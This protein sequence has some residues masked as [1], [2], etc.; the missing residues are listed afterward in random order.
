MHFTLLEEGR[1]KGW[2]KLDNL[3]VDH[4]LLDNLH[5][6]T[7]ELLLAKDP[8]NDTNI[9]SALFWWSIQ[10]PNVCPSPV[11]F[12]PEER[13]QRLIR[14]RGATGTPTLINIARN[15]VLSGI[16]F[17]KED[18][19]LNNDQGVFLVH[20][21]AYSGNLSLFALPD[22]EP[23]LFKTTKNGSSACH[24][25]AQGGHIAKLPENLL[26]SEQ[27]R[28]CTANG[29]RPVH[30]AA[31]HGK[32]KEF[33][34]Q[35]P[36]HLAGKEEICS[37]DKSGYNYAHLVAERHLEPMHPGWPYLN[38]MLLV[39]DNMG[40]NPLHL[41]FAEPNETN[42]KL[43]PKSVFTRR[44]LRM[45][46]KK[47]RVPFKNNG[48]ERSDLASLLHNYDFTPDEKRRFRVTDLLGQSYKYIG[49]PPIQVE[50]PNL[51]TD[52]IQ[53]VIHQLDP[54]N[55]ASTC[56]QEKAYR[57]SLELLLNEP[58]QRITKILGPAWLRK[59]LEDILRGT[60]GQQAMKVISNLIPP[61]NTDN[62]IF[63]L[64]Q[65]GHLDLTLLGIQSSENFIDLRKQVLTRLQQ[66]VHSAPKSFNGCVLAYCRTWVQWE[67]L[68]PD[69]ARKLHPLIM[70]NSPQ[71]FK[72]KSFLPIFEAAL[73]ELKDS[74][75]AL[76]AAVGVAYRL[77]VVYG[78]IQEVKKAV[79]MPA[80]CKNPLD[81]INYP[82]FELA[83]FSL[84]TNGIWSIKEWRK[85]LMQRPTKAQIRTIVRAPEIEKLLG[86]APTGW[87]EINQTIIKL[88]ERKHGLPDG[89]IRLGQQFFLTEAQILD[90]QRLLKKAKT[91]ENCPP[92][93]F[94]HAGNIFRQLAPLDPLG[95]ML[96]YTTKC[97]QILH[98][99]GAMYASTGVTDP[100]AAFYALFSGETVIAHTF[101]WRTSGT[102]VFDSW[103]H[104][105]AGKKVGE[106]IIRRAAKQALELDPTIT[107][108][109]LGVGGVTPP[110][111]FPLAQPV[112]WKQPW[113]LK[114]GR[115]T[116]SNMQYLVASRHPQEEY[117]AEKHASEREELNKLLNQGKIPTEARFWNPSL[118]LDVSQPVLPFT[119]LMSNLI[120]ASEGEFNAAQLH[121]RLGEV[122]PDWLHVADKKQKTSLEYILSIKGSLARIPL[123]WLPTADNALEACSFLE[124]IN[125]A[126]ARGITT[127]EGE[128]LAAMLSPDVLKQKWRDISILYHLPVNKLKRRF[129]DKLIQEIVN[130][131][132]SGASDSEWSLI[133]QNGFLPYAPFIPLRQHLVKSPALL[134]SIAQAGKLAELPAGVASPVISHFKKLKN[135]KGYENTFIDF[136]RDALQNN[137]RQVVRKT[138][139]P[140]KW[141]IED[142]NGCTL[143][144]KL[145]K[146]QL[147]ANLESIPAHAF[148]L[149][150]NEH[151]PIQ[152]IIE[153]KEIQ[154]YP[155]LLTPQ[156]LLGTA[157]AVP[158]EPVLILAV[159]HLEQIPHQCLQDAIQYAQKEVPA[160]LELFLST[161]AREGKLAKLPSD[162]LTK[163]L[164]ESK[165][166][167][168]ALSLQMAAVGVAG[169]PVASRNLFR[170]AFKR[171]FVWEKIPL[172]HVPGV[173]QI[174]TIRAFSREH[175]I[176]ETV[177]ALTALGSDF[178]SRLGL[179]THTLSDQTSV[180]HH[181]FNLGSLNALQSCCIQ[182]P[183]QP[184]NGLGETPLQVA[185]RSGNYQDD[186][187]RLWQWR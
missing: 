119:L 113:R 182:P 83:D 156:A 30:L 16:K 186:L 79:V 82:L 66:L 63:K 51:N 93:R 129:E 158:T 52:S 98:E 176:E 39:Q 128:R 48:L 165:E 132:I 105:D 185:L 3:V 13:L 111:P 169:L 133:I 5:L 33:F 107:A 102:L 153:R 160:N 126:L 62:F 118:L 146:G 57:L 138:L 61:P 50:L 100:D 179:Q 103:E 162:L 124:L 142:T 11:S 29:R 155:Q 36:S 18:L 10:Q 19:A 9:L 54:A 173:W 92:I 17:T 101:A 154:N 181:L 150:A 73:R 130:A 106:E 68:F 143:L 180:M 110:M 134:F 75:K 45:F 167:T 21:L 170:Q 122:E 32:V 135:Q 56:A 174:K 99:N 4:K 117:T 125:P 131:T 85:L 175:T 77:C 114:C 147:P 112:P 145:E 47:H 42:L 84:P 141:A 184:K 34:E 97:C 43:T 89:L 2:S 171:S 64:Y 87:K 109:H 115:P 151:L 80:C 53:Q 55:E 139:V 116:D 140:P 144:H 72:A 163:D 120:Q 74:D 35:L 86:R 168:H 59:D 15:G 152:T 69:I 159:D 28:L 22:L 187:I 65:E 104:T 49:T 166:C 78:T 24:Y 108:V 183:F 70:M 27:F 67:L 178:N 71:G 96:G 90:Y 25:A 14:Q 7:D 37:L 136:L 172:S 121:M 95:P 88:D 161:L 148:Y 164:L 12:L 137:S 8:H 58:I 123:E 81:H 40:N 23:Y 41:A 91:R 149:S 20:A 177:A 1:Y 31:Y 60:R 46:N 6:I 76:Q 94:T 157:Q 26:T 38:E 44:N 127:E